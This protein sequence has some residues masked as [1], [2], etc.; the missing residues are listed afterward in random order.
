MAGNSP[1]TLDSYTLCFLNCRHLLVSSEQ[2]IGNDLSTS[3]HEVLSPA[4]DYELF[5]CFF[6]GVCADIA[7]QAQHTQY[8]SGD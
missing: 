7:R 1:L 5:E 3:A 8:G 6:N 2:S 4:G